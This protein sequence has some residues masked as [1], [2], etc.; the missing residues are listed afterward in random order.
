MNR[1]T[2]NI[3]TAYTIFLAASLSPNVFAD[4]GR[5]PDFETLGV[6]VSDATLESNRGGYTIESNTNNLNGKLYDNQANANVTGSNYVTAGAFAGTSGFATVVQNSGNNV[7]IQ[8]ATILNVR[9]Q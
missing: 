4:E 8:N 1:L 9:M 5:K 2:Y 6:A 3:A 7:L